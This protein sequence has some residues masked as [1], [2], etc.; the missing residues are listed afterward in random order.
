MRDAWWTPASK[1]ITIPVLGA[2]NTAGKIL[3]NNVRAPSRSI[4]PQW[5]INSISFGSPHVRP[6]GVHRTCGEH[7]ETKKDTHPK[8]ITA[9]LREQVKIKVGVEAD[10]EVAWT[11]NVLAETNGGNANATVVVGAHLD[12]VPEGPGINDNGTPRAVS[13]SNP[14]RWG[15]IRF[16]LAPRTY[17]PCGVHRTCGA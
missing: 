11:F 16:R 9:P 2:S 3:V 6:M 7:N 17:A 1:T 15:S 14:P 5:G 8:Y 10:Y 4:S 12:S 13:R